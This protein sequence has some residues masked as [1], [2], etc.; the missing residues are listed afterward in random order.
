[1]R[2]TYERKAMNYS[3][4]TRLA[5]ASGLVALVVGGLVPTAANADPIAATGKSPYGQLAGTGSD[6]TQD[7]MNGLQI[8]IGR[9]AGTGGVNPDD[10]WKLTSY[11]ATSTVE[12]QTLVT[13]YGGNTIYRP[14][15]SSD[16]RDAL[17][18]AIGQK[19]N[20]TGKYT[21]A[22]PSPGASVSW[23][24]DSL[25]AAADQVF[26]QV[27]YARSSAGPTTNVST[28]GAVSYVPFAKDAVDYAV[29]ANSVLPALSVG[30]DQDAANVVTNVAPN[31]LFAIYLCEATRVITKVGQATKL[32]NDDYTLG[33]GESS[34]DIN[35]YIPQSSSGTGKFWALKFYGAEGASLPACVTR[36][37]PE[38]TV[39]GEVIPAGSV[40]EHDGTAITMDAG[41]ITPFSIPKW[42]AMAKHTAN[43][44]G[45]EGVNDVREGAV[46]GTLNGIAPTAGSGSNLKMNPTFLTNGSTSFLARSV[47][48]IVPY[49]LLTDPSSLEYA[50]F[51]GRNS[52]ICQNSATISAYGF[53]LLTATSGANSCGF[54]GTRAYSFVA[55]T[56]ASAPTATLDNTD[57]EVDFNLS[58]FT[59]SNGGN[60]GAKIY[61]VAT[62][63]DGSEVYTVNPEDPEILAADT[64]AKTFS[65]P[66]SDLR[67]GTWNL[68]IEVHSNLA[69][70]SVYGTYGLVTKSVIR[71]ETTVS[72]TVSGKAKRFGKAV[73]TVS[74]ASGTPTGTVTLRRKNANGA[75][76]GT[77]ELTA[78]T[79]TI[80]NLTK[81]R[82]KGKLKVYVEYSGDADFS[83]SSKTVTWNVK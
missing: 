40:Q 29:S 63:L 46:L 56:V 30:T 38:R 36:T 82:S 4:K 75:V 58:T 70:V 74:A 7:V 52:L 83:A 27:Q 55:P 23:K 22:T 21:Y 44:A 69:G 54:T 41:G 24:A 31:T 68:G 81:Q 25:I 59:V 50:M 64:T 77:G 1:M 66:F 61:V 14:N 60:R 48:N 39:G 80:T 17:L 45:F 62:A 8:A 79:V 78:G 28:T 76:I 47:Y 10:Y 19:G 5:A 12:N 67:E 65:V 37:Y 9:V 57:E 72:A 51:N 43:V 73:V 33:T 13:K 53:G 18:T 34:T 6:T 32:V 26:G 20:T 35:A 49:R 71:T 15:G 16:G 42:V 2:Q 11:D 3:F